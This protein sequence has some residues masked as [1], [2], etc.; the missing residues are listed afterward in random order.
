M[1]KCY[2]NKM[3]KESKGKGQQIYEFTRLLE[4]KYTALLI[5][6]SGRL[7]MYYEIQWAFIHRKVTAENGSTRRY[8]RT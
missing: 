4:L 8:V 3:E 7:T 5:R 2:Q 1:Q 6:R